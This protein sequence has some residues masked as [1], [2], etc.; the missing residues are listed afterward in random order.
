M[1]SLT[2]V[3]ITFTPPATARSLSPPSRLAQAW[4]IATIEDEHAVSIVRLGPRRS[5]SNE[6][7][8]DSA[9]W[10]APDAV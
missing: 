3:T 7:R 8:F 4:W 6:M 1:T 5:S 9:A 10:D 2:G